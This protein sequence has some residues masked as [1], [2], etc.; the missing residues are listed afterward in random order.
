M[1]YNTPEGKVKKRGRELLRKYGHYSFPVNQGGMCV[2][3]IPDD[4]ACIHGRFVH[5]EY[6]AD[7]D[8]RQKKSAYK[9][10]PTEQ[11][12]AR[13]DECRASGGVTW[14]VDIHNLDQMDEML[15]Y[16]EHNKALIDQGWYTEADFDD[17]LDWAL[18]NPGLEFRVSLKDFVN[19][20]AEK[21]EPRNLTIWVESRSNVQ[22]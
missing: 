1:S 20:K 19:W 12:V 14:L 10:L 7:M 17:F 16:L 4:V 22:Q 15:S 13:M 2:K 21:E 9:T 11:Q 18:G 6:K 3:G 5:I 8:W